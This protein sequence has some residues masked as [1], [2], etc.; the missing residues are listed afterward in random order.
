[1][2]VSLP[3]GIRRIGRTGRVVLD[4]LPLIGLLMEVVIGRLVGGRNHHIVVDE[5]V[6]RQL[7]DGGGYDK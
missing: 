7:A 4:V 1:M 6:A 5:I 3:D 2:I